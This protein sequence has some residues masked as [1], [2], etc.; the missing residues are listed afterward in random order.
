MRRPQ[1][2]GWRACRRMARIG[3]DF[4]RKRQ[5][6]V[7]GENRQRLAIDFMIRRTSAPQIVVIHRGQIVVNQRIGMNAF[8]RRRRK[9]DLRAR[10]AEEFGGH[11]QHDRAQALSA[12][13]RAVAHGLVQPRRKRLG[14]R[15]RGVQR[16]R[17]HPPFFIE[18]RRDIRRLFHHFGSVGLT[19]LS[20]H[21]YLLLLIHIPSKINTLDKNHIFRRVHRENDA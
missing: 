13:Q 12:R 1:N 19:F 21:F 20:A 15:K 7:S 6:R 9:R 4:E 11:Q 8:Q 17:D 18:I 16:L 14:R 5:Q 10:F 3:H 2:G